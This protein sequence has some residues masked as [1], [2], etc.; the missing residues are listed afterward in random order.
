M[1]KLHTRC[2]SEIPAYFQVGAAYRLGTGEEISVSAEGNL[3]SA[4]D[5]CDSM[6]VE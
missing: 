3:P 4:E 2:E 5:E 1:S 6:A